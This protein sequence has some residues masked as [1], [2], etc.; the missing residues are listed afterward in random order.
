MT[1]S[2]S[3][4]TY[5][6]LVWKAIEIQIGTSHRWIG[7]PFKFLEPVIYKLTL[8]FPSFLADRRVDESQDL[9]ENGFLAQHCTSILPFK[10]NYERGQEKKKDF[11]FKA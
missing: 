7:T 2:T 3:V 1:I 11:L 4:C 8:N 9:S 10:K 6:V 5:G